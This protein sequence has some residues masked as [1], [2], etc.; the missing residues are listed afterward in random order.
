MAAAQED[1]FFGRRCSGALECGGLTPPWNQTSG[2]EFERRRRWLWPPHSKAVP[3]CGAAALTFLVACGLVVPKAPSGAAAADDCDEAAL[4][5][6]EPEA[7]GF[8]GDIYSA[9][10]CG[11]G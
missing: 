2:W 11:P 1:G 7:H 10:C 8:A 4:N 6:S 5:G 9:R 3:A